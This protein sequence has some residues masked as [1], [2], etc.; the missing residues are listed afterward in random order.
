[1]SKYIDRIELSNNTSSGKIIKM[2][3][4][5][6]T[7]LEFGPSSG[8][9]TKYLSR[10]LKCRV[11]IVEINEEDF[12]KAIRYA[13]DGI[14]DDLMSFSWKEKFSEI[15]FDY[16]LFT[17]VLEHL[18]NPNLALRNAK[19]LL[20]D[21]GDILI[22]IPN[23]AH[24]DIILSLFSNQ[25]RYT[26]RG[27]LDD[28]HV[29]FWGYYDLE[30]FFKSEGLKIVEKEAIYQK[31]FTTEQN[32]IRTDKVEKLYNDY[33]KNREFGEVYQF[34]IRVKKEEASYENENIALENK[35]NMMISNIYYNS[36]SGY[37]ELD[38]RTV[39]IPKSDEGCFSFKLQ[40]Y[41]G[42]T[43]MIRFDPVE[44]E[45][46]MLSDFEIL[47][48]SGPLSYNCFNAVSIDKYI[49]FTTSDPQ[50][51]IRIPE[52]VNWIKIVGKVNT[53]NNAEWLELAKRI[54]SIEM[55]ETI[56]SNFYYD[57]GD[58]FNAFDVCVEY[59]KNI[60]EKYM[61][62]VEFPSEVR[63][64][65]FDPVEDV[66]CLIK[67]LTVDSTSNIKQIISNGEELRDGFLIQNDDPQIKIEFENPIKQIRVFCKIETL[68]RKSI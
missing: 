55:K 28:T 43:H 5:G 65:R 9:I 31:T 66:G 37:S 60:G 2:I 39:F 45:F 7:I 25:F 54:T 56:K 32:L 52:G 1:M 26:S 3:K 51:E 10:R 14:C 42:D 38:K 34:I 35:A 30:G 68:S 62:E 8:R 50:V 6:S 20:K 57:K 58:G 13:E 63:T 16:I 49:Y 24:N 21:D 48:E 36:G 12:K 11:Y 61:Y 19:E 67:N 18:T 41:D 27:L 44:D 29:H 33:L 17:D 47:S 59:T 22:S 23:I 40:I 53:T 46:C 64:I 4:K 15:K